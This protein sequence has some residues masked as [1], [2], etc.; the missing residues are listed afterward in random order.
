MASCGGEIDASK[1]AASAPM[2][3]GAPNVD[4]RAPPAEAGRCTIDVSN[5]DQSCS[6]DSDCVNVAGKFT[7][8][9]GNYCEMFCMCAGDAISRVA[10]SQYIRDVSATP[11]G[12]GAIPQPLCGCGLYPQPCCAQGRCSTG[13]P[14]FEALMVDAAAKDQATD[15]DAVPPGSFM[16]GLN[17]GP[18]DGGADAGEPWRW[19]TP[20]QS[21]LPFNGGW[22]C[23]VQPNGGV[24]VCSAPV[25]AGEGGN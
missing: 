15:A 7:V 25:G 9:S 5:Y 23:C 1:D 20:P 21:C 22:A 6:S 2:D 4:V 16:C 19:C 24:S 11:L 12:S 17:T 14:C 13:G 8:Q 18:L 10:V 3:G